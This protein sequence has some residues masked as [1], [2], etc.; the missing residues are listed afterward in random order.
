MLCDDR[1]IEVIRNNT[2]VCTYRGDGEDVEFEWVDQQELSRIALQR[3]IRGRQQTCCYYLRITQAD[4]D[5]AWTSPIWFVDQQISPDSSVI[6][7]IHAR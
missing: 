3:T 4:G 6:S 2:E 7:A 1:P 5:I